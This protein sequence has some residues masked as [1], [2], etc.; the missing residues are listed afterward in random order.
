[1]YSLLKL[2]PVKYR[3]YMLLTMIATI[4]QSVSSLIFSRVTAS[5]IPLIAHPDIV[6]TSLNIDGIHIPVSGHGEAIGVLLAIL[7]AAIILTFAFA[8][9]SI[10]LSTKVTTNTVRIM[11]TVAFKRVQEI[12]AKDL[13]KISVGSL[14]SRMTNDIWIVG[15]ALAN[16]SRS[17]IMAPIMIIGATLMAIIVNPGIS[18]FVAII[19]PVIFVVVLIIGLTTVPLIKKRQKQNDLINNES[20][21]NIHGIRVIKSYNLEKIQKEKY[22]SVTKKWAK[23]AIKINSN[24]SF[25]IPIVFFI[26]NIVTGFIILWGA[27][28]INPTSTDTKF[29]ESLMAFIDFMILIAMSILQFTMVL[30]MSFRGN[31]SAKRI[32]AIIKNKDSFLPVINGKNIENPSIEFKNVSFAYSEEDAQSNNFIINNISFAVQPYSTLGIIGSSGAGKSTIAELLIRNYLPNH[33][34]ILVDNKNIN[35]I[36]TSDLND[37]IAMTFQDSILNSGSIKKNL[38]FAKET[39]T[40]EEIEK[41]CKTARA[42]E[43]IEKF[44]DKFEHI[45]EQRGKNLSGGQKQR[46]SI[47]RSLLKDAKILVLDDST[48]ALDALTEKKVKQGIR[49][50]YNQTTLIISQKISAIRDCDNIILLEDGRIEAQGSHEYLMTNSQKYKQI[51]KEQGGV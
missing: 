33:G 14:M 31:I 35:E 24:F 2:A 25:I 28:S 32:N 6:V 11:R 38:L 46:L 16:F 18:F 41:A 30:M 27:N 44:D 45:I 37:N 26:V 10:V 9:V 21:E 22:L 48:S 5:F 40:K 19:I 43:F 12:P 17:L 3:I 15:L 7:F 29:L 42:F 51:V 39:A 13:D 1:M 36:N 4:L 20:R 23:L 50:N 34:E 47:A 49:K 8:F